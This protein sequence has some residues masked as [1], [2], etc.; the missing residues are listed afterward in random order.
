MARVLDNPRSGERIVIRHSGAD[1]AGE[2]LEF[3][4]FLQPGAHV[5]A[6][7]AHPC[8]QEQFRVLTGQV[9]FRVAGRDV[10]VGPGNCLT[11]PAGTR[12]WF[13]NAGP[14]VAQL[15]VEVRPALR[16]QE[17]FETTI[18]CSGSASA[19]W[20]RLLD[21][22]LIPLDFQREVAVPNV[23][24]WLVTTLLSPLAWLR[25]RLRR[26]LQVQVRVRSGMSPSRSAVP[27]A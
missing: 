9:R 26:R 8:Q 7:H 12:H 4:V 24:A 17:L 22:A 21:W 13:G 6:G 14:S 27:G 1:T 10:V 19:W 3:D 18:R 5:P 11:V 2:L 15:R 16:M 23:P 20:T 25:L